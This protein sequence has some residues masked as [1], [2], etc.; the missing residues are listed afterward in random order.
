MNC[1]L[2][3]YKCLNNFKKVGRTRQSR[4]IWKQCK[5]KFHSG[6]KTCGNSLKQKSVKRTPA[7]T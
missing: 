4:M 2:N 6:R 1:G 5:P 7:I 3:K